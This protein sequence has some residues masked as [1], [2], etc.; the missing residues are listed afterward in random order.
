MPEYSK[1][2][3]MPIGA[4]ITGIRMSESD[5]AIKPLAFPVT[6]VETDSKKGFIF[7]YKNFNSS[8]RVEVF[9]ARGTL[10]EW[11]KAKCSD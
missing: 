8:M 3:D 6:Q 11:E 5:D 4:T 9:I 10:V 1:V 7:I 2:E